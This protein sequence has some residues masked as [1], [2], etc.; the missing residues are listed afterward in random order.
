VGNPAG[1]Y[2]LL[3]AYIPLPRTRADRASARDPRPSIEERYSSRDAYLRRV[4]AAAME[5]VKNRYVLDED[6][7]S[8]TTRAGAH[9]DW[10]TN[11]SK[12]NSQ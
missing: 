7:E 3:G 12:P 4:R 10:A 5:L 11:G 2:P 1:L 6:V 9:W 8:I